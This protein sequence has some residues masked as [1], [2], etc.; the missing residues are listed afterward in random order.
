MGVTLEVI[1]CGILQPLAD[2]IQVID[3]RLGA[4]TQA[5]HLAPAMPLEKV[6][7]G[8]EFARHVDGG[9]NFIALGEMGIGNTFV[10]SAVMSA[11]LNIN[12]A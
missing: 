2:Q 6:A 5:I 12:I 9:C 4:G 11:M 8:F 10:A 3:Q 1:D 7:Q